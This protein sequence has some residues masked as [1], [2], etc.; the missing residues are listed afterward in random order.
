MEI[1]WATSELGYSALRPKQ[2]L[3]VRHFLRGS[4]VFVSLPKG[5]C[6]SLCY[7]LLSRAFDFSSSS[8]CTPLRPPRRFTCYISSCNFPLMSFSSSLSPQTVYGTVFEPRKSTSR[9]LS[10]LPKH[11]LPP[12]SKVANKLTGRTKY[13]SY[14]PLRRK[15]LQ[16]EQLYTILAVPMHNT[17][18]G[19]YFLAII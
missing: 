15:T 10:A 9:N 16:S 6:K 17:Y 19:D 8:R 7:C 13:F 5:S 2:E 12:A 3:S 4:D 18:S 11:W 14:V 1:S